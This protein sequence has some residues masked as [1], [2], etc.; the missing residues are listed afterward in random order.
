MVQLG[1]NASRISSALH[2][3]AVKGTVKP[4]SDCAVMWLPIANANIFLNTK[5]DYSRTN[6][7]TD[8]RTGGRTEDYF[9]PGGVLTCQC[10]SRDSLRPHYDCK[11][12]V[13]CYFC[14]ISVLRRDTSIKV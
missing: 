3:T 11:F 12:S 1:V 2:A 10:D 9:G 4:D 6:E 7:R 5:H 13:P 14:S 8:G